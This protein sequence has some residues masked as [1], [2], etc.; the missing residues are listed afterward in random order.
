MRYWSE[1]SPDVVMEKVA[2]GETE[3]RLGN[4]QPDTSYEILAYSLYKNRLSEPPA[5]ARLTSS[6]AVGE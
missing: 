2:N 5:F 4:L 1:D 3:V 6:N